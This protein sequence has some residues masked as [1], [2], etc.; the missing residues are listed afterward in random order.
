MPHEAKDKDW[1]EWFDALRAYHTRFGKSPPRLRRV[2][3][4]DRSEE[5]RLLREAVRTGVKIGEEPKS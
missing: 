4:F 2:I 1:T 5:S 3:R